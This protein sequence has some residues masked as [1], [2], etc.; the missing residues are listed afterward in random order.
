MFN[1]VVYEGTHLVFTD[2][3][4]LIHWFA[5]ISPNVRCVGAM[6]FLGEVS[7][8][9]KEKLSQKNSTVVLSGMQDGYIDRYINR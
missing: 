7:N 4:R 5:L 2:K 1:A 8:G 3:Q 9:N 6:P